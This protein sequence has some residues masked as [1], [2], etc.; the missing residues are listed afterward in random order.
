MYINYIIDRRAGSP[1]SFTVACLLLLSLLAFFFYC[2]SAPSFIVA[3]LTSPQARRYA[4]TQTIYPAAQPSDLSQ[5]QLGLEQASHEHEVLTRSIHNMRHTQSR[6]VI[7]HT[8]QYQ[9]GLKQA[10]HEYKI[11]MQSIHNA[12]HTQDRHII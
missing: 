9:L 7:R 8:S 1:P 12:K 5:F 11:L 2:C 3:C 10:S 4:F 6:H